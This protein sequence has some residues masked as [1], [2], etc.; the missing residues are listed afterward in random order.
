MRNTKIGTNAEFTTLHNRKKKRRKKV[1]T[2]LN[3]HIITYIL[4]VLVH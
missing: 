1:V 2:K 3:Q 4:S